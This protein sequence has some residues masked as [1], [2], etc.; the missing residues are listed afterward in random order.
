V[1]PLDVVSDHELAVQV[2]DRVVGAVRAVIEGEQADVSTISVVLTGHQTVR[3]L[4]TSYLDHDYDTD[5]LAFDLRDQEDDPVDGEVY[6]DLDTAVEYCAETD[7][8]LA[9][10]AARYAV[11][12]VL[13]L[14]G[15]RDETPSGKAAMRALED[16]YLG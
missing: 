9:R 3:S 11:H 8:E 1:D 16:R 10:E 6:V 2:H 5:V 12:G 4:N 15:H 7:E 14:L 13:H